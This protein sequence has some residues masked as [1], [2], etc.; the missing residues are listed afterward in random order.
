MFSSNLSNYSEGVNT[1]FIVI[2]SITIFFLIALTIA[3]IYFIIRYR[4]SKNPEAT[5]IHGNLTLEIVWTTIP[6]LI[7]L[8]MF[9]FGWTAWKPMESKPPD[10]AMHIETVAR[11]WKWNFKYPNGTRTDTLIIPAGQ[12]VALDMESVDVIH[13]LYIPAFRIKKDVNPGTP[14]TAWFIANSP[15]SYDLF[16]AEY[17]GLQHSYMITTVKVLPQEEFNKWYSDTVSSSAPAEGELAEAATTAQLGAKIL[18]QI[19]CN[20]CH[21][22]DGSTIVGPSYKGLFGHKITVIA[23]GQEKEVTADEEYIRRSILE[24]DAEVVK[25]FSKGLMQSYK[26]QLSDEEIDQIIDYLKTLN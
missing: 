12:P 20:A 14:R 23:N 22:L 17:C 21:S 4:R 18:Q 3:L 19:G 1:A 6:V 2:L 24:P 11:M 7:V 9:Y 25:G 26:G 8:A 5:Q 10:N 16:C 13:S 15:G